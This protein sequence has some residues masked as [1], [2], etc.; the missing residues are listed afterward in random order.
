M[1]NVFCRRKFLS[2]CVATSVVLPSVANPKLQFPRP[3][4]YL[5]QEVLAPSESE[6]GMQHTRAVIIGMAFNLTGYEPSG[7]WYLPQWVDNPQSPWMVG[8]DD[9]HFWHERW[10]KAV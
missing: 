6:E 5:G 2:G 1:S 3:K 8:R 9:G 4:F 7:W 10:I